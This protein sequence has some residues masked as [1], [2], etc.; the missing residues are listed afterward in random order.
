MTARFRGRKPTNDYLPDADA[1]TAEEMR[2]IR[3]AA[4]VSTIP[5][6][7]GLARALAT[8][9]A[10]PIEELAPADKPKKGKRA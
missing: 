10:E 7:E 3:G 5:G 2:R 4:E 1:L 8:G 9:S 6:L